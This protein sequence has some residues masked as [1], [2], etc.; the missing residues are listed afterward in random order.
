MIIDKN[1]MLQSFKKWSYGL[2]RRAIMW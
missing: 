1:L 2:W